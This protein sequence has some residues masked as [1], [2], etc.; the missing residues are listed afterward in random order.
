MYGLTDVP[1]LVTFD[2]ARPARIHRLGP[3][4]G[5]AEGSSLLAIDI[6]P[7]DGR[8]FA[9]SDASISS[10]PSIPA[11]GV[12]TAVG[13]ATDPPRRR[14]GFGFDLD[15]ATDRVRSTSPRAGPEHRLATS[16]TTTHSDLAYARQKQRRRRRPHRRRLLTTARL[17]RRRH[18][19][20]QTFAQQA[21]R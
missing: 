15:P 9:L 10:T 20:Q 6:R 1:E 17:L 7:V 4:T 8:L 16:T 2:A 12:A 13:P 5:V 11:T 18:S 19:N 3:I 14:P 21:T